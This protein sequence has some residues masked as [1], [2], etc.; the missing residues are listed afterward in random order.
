[1]MVEGFGS[2][3]QPPMDSRTRPSGGAQRRLLVS[4]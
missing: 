2:F 1:M 3:T 4:G